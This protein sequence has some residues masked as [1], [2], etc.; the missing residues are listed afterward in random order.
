MNGRRDM[1]KLKVV[2]EAQLTKQDL[3][4]IDAKKKNQFAATND[5]CHNA[6]LNNVLYASC[7]I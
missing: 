3:D 4:S 6:T 1:R 5:N 2:M 7:L